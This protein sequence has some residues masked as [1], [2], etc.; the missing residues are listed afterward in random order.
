MKASCKHCGIAIAID[1][2]LE[3][4]SNICRDCAKRFRER[5]SGVKRYPK[6]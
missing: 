2:K 6:R 5:L 4:L 1:K 3:Y